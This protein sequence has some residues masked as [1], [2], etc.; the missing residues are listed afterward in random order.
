MENLSLYN[1]YRKVPATAKKEITAGRLKG[2]TD[3]N[4]MWRIKCLTEEF[5]PCGIG[6]YYEIT[7]KNVIPGDN[8][9]AVCV[10]QINLY[11]KIKDEAGEKWSYPIV[12][13][14]GSSFISKEKSGLYTSDECFKSA[15][16]DA[17]SVACKALGIGADVYYSKDV[18][19]YSQKEASEIKDE[20]A[21]I[22][23]MKIT[24]T[25]IEILK[26]IY[27]GTNYNK[28]L[29]MNG[30]EKIEDMTMVK[31]SEIIRLVRQKA[32][33]KNGIVQN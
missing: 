11:F 25:Q 21:D 31:A 19:K 24:G 5:G 23:E 22:K 20:E 1:K 4:P 26:K 6:W 14:G 13:I 2:F 16:T 33:A 27:K 10:V 15:L 30:I 29:E 12:G 18:T 8:G 17:I 3:I 28:L 32:E 9:Q 7:E